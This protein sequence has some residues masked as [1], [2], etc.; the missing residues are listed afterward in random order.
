[1]N[2]IRNVIVEESG[3]KWLLKDLYY[4]TQKSYSTLIGAIRSIKKDDNRIAS[5]SNIV[6][7]KTTII[8]NTKQGEEL[9]KAL[10]TEGNQN[11]KLHKSR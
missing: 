9:V 11:G 8:Y 4:D 10:N 1:M 6:V 3:K 2:V 5:K 7:T